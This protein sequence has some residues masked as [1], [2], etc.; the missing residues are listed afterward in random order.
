MKLRKTACSLMLILSLVFPV[1]SSAEEN[2]CTSAWC[3]GIR[4][5]DNLG[6][7]AWWMSRF[8][9]AGDK[10]GEKIEGAIVNVALQQLG[11]Y[12]PFLSIGSTGPSELDLATKR[13]L[14]AIERT[15]TNI[16]NAIVAESLIQNGIN[17]DSLKFD[18]AY[19]FSYPQYDRQTL[20]YLLTSLLERS[21]TLRLAFQVD[22]TNTN[23]NRAFDTY[24]YDSFHTYMSLVALQ[25]TIMIEH[26]RMTKLRSNPRATN[27]EIQYQVLTNLRLL[28]N[29]SDPNSPFSYIAWLD[30]NWKKASDIRFANVYGFINSGS[31]Y[32][33]LYNGQIS[34]YQ[35]LFP[36]T[37]LNPYN[38]R[39]TRWTYTFDGIPHTMKRKTWPCYVRFGGYSYTQVNFHVYFNTIGNVIGATNRWEAEDFK[40]KQKVLDILKQQQFPIYLRRVYEP[41]RDVLNS[42][43]KLAQLPG[44]RPVLNADR[45]F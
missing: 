16:I 30:N 3:T 33:P 11:P 34:Q 45:Y 1:G 42:W 41:A 20:Y 32:N 37:C 36:L 39:E 14:D 8:D 26:T 28:F 9:R 44:N 40:Y 35:Y 6:D 2:Q 22:R 27:Q 13:I 21:T 12:L 17:W 23:P 5:L 10:I 31:E 38:S 24:N 25:T 18:T 7:K 4:P 43:W 15:E 19:Y 29:P